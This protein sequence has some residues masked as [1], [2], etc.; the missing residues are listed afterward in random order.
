MARNSLYS[1]IISTKT[2]ASILWIYGLFLDSIGQ[3]LEAIRYLENA[4]QYFTN[5]DCRD[6]EYYQCISKLA[7]L[8]LVEYEKTGNRDYLD[9]AKPIG[10]ILYD[11]RGDYATDRNTKVSATEINRKL[12]AIR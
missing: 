10:T 12:K 5:I 8:Y 11:N 6:I 1:N 2:Y 4:M 3:C 9:R 7:S